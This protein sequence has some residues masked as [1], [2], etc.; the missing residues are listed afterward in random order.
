[1][2]A[3][4][5]ETLQAW[6]R[7]ARPRTLTATYVPLG[8]AAVIALQEGVFD[9]GRFVLSLGGALLLQVAAN[10]INEYFDF[11]RGADEL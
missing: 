6:Y 2:A 7:A 5:R 1:M 8:L 9:L 3:V 10:L 4:S 11:R